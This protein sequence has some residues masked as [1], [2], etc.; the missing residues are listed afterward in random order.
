M[1]V[2]IISKRIIEIVWEEYTEVGGTEGVI[3][4]GTQGKL[5][6]YSVVILW[7]SDEEHEDGYRFF[8]QC[9]DDYGNEKCI[10]TEIGEVE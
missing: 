9:H 7:Y 10:T 1:K 2:D 3:L 6:N 8:I 4:V 5:K